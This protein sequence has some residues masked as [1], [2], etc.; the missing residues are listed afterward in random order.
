MYWLFFL[1]VE[2]FLFVS[3]YLWY[4]CFLYI[5][6]FFFSS[7][8]LLLPTHLPPP[9]CPHAQSCNPMDCSPPGSSV[10]GL[11]QARILEWVAISFSCFLYVFKE[12]YCC[13][14]NFVKKPLAVAWI[15][16]YILFGSHLMVQ[17][18]QYLYILYFSHYIFI[19]FV[20]CFS[21]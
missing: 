19:S 5:Y 21:F 11:F 1:T 15:I 8:T 14:H 10:H 16:R 6:I 20:E 17:Q 2:I 7:P 12:S 3:A 18:W 4:F 9:S 13:L